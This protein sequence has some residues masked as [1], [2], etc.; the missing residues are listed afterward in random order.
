[1]GLF[2]AGLQVEMD[3]W[4]GRRPDNSHTLQCRVW[5]KDACMQ[6]LRMPQ[7]A[8]WASSSL[9]KISN[10]WRPSCIRTNMYTSI[11]NVPAATTRYV[12]VWHA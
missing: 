4:G 9:A 8:R 5:T 12:P 2:R 1:M 3:A 10:L 11:Q 6:E 7:L